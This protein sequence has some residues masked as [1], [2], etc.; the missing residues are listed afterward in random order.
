[1]ELGDNGSWLFSVLA[2]L[3]AD[4]AYNVHDMKSA[5]FKKCG[6][7]VRERCSLRMKP[8]LQAECHTRPSVSPSGQFC[9]LVNIV[10]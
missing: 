10:V 3:R 4:R 7:F 1:M 2:R 9:I 8:R 6:Y 5:G